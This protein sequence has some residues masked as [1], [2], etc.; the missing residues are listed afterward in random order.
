MIS[1]PEMAES[2]LNVRVYKNH[3]FGNSKVKEK[4]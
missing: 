4:I 2:N 1:E 3:H